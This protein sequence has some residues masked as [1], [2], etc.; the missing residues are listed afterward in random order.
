MIPQY[1]YT[2][3]VY[4]YL[5]LN[6][7]NIMYMSLPKPRNLQWELIE[8]IFFFI[9][10]FS[11]TCNNI[12]SAT[13]YEYACVSYQDLVDRT[14]VWRYQGVIR[15]CNPKNRQYIGQKKKD[16]KMVHK[17]L[18]RKPKIE[19]H[20]PHQKYLLLTKEDTEPSVPSWSHHF[21]SFI[22]HNMPSYVPRPSPEYSCGKRNLLYATRAASFV[23]IVVYLIHSSQIVSSDRK[24]ARAGLILLVDLY[25]DL[26]K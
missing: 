14:T 3:Y 10:K 11:F 18:Y 15:L 13:G 2:M 4:F 1:R 5:H 22:V 7:R 24:G 12:S 21:E 19:Q 23:S 8:I 9:V 25:F 26:R 17:I 20:E 16:K 6:Q